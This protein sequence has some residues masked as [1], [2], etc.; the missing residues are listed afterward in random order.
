MH[1][2][3]DSEEE[4]DVDPIDAQEIFG[5][6]SA[7]QTNPTLIA[8]D[9]IRSISDPEHPLSLESLRVVSV[10]QVELGENSVMVEFTPTV[11][12]CGMSTIIGIKTMA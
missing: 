6:S 11:P 12:H 4:N 10:E 5:Q 2:E 8:A 3:E 7:E 1:V 9:L